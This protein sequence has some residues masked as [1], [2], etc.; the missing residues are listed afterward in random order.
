MDERLAS[1]AKHFDEKN[2]EKHREI[3]W[4]RLATPYVKKAVYP[5]GDQ[6]AFL[7]EIVVVD[8]PGLALA[9]GDMQQEAHYFKLLKSSTVDAIDISE[10]SLHKAKDHCKQLGLNVNF[11]VADVNKIKLPKKHYGLIVIAHSFHHFDEVERIA[12]QIA[13][14]MLPDGVFILI[15]YIGSRYLQYS[16][17][18][19]RYANEF[20]KQLPASLRVDLAGG[21]RNEIQPP[22]RWGLSVHEAIQSPNIMP[23]I[24]SNFS[25]IKGSLYGGLMHPLLDRI[26]GSFSQNNP[27]HV[28]ILDELWQKDKELIDQKKLEPNFCE[29]VLVRKNSQLSRKYKPKR[30]K[31]LAAEVDDRYEWLAQTA[32]Q[33]IWRLREKIA[34]Y[35][36]TVK[37]RDALID[38][39]SH[40]SFKKRVIRKIKKKILR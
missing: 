37:K 24:E 14:S 25:C 36:A 40:R 27:K 18:Q 10:E 15:D 35:Q 26:A 8:K 28:K 16:T 31:Y 6:E 4:S 39:M 23:A 22:L 5:N 38:Q 30:F 34:A 1:E 7:K 20:L 29:L 32:S 11:S 9:C 17:R 19:L 33:E 12:K 2:I 21:V 3:S 13:D